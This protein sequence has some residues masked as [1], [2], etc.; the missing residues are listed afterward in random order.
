MSDSTP[1]VLLVEDNDLDAM[2]IQRAFRALKVTREVTRVHDGIEAIEA[3]HGAPTAP[4]IARPC[5]VLLDLNMPRMNGIEFLEKRLEDP[6]LLA[7]P[8]FVLTTSQDPL[9]V[10]RANRLA[11]AGYLIKALAMSEMLKTLAAAEEFWR[12]CHL[13]DSETACPG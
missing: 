12:A 2:K 4:R 3:I 6:E 8:V 13:P 5:V 11:I 7:S 9:D 10:Q 1:S